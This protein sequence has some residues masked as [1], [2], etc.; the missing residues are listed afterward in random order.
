[1]Y[2]FFFNRIIPKSLNKKKVKQKK[3]TSRAN[4]KAKNFPNRTKGLPQ[5][6]FHVGPKGQWK[7]ITHVF[8]NYLNEKKKTKLKTQ[9]TK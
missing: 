5:I 2:N 1:M 8:P 6:N 7:V 4:K 3:A 9:Y